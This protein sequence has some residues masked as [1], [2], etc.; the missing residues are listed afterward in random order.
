MLQVPR[1]LLSGSG[2]RPVMVNLKHL[3]LIFSTV[4]ALAAGVSCHTRSSSPSIILR[5]H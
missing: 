4:M 1:V 3:L 2:K 5:P